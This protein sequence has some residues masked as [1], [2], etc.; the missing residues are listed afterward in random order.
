MIEGGERKLIVTG[1]FNLLS[2]NS[3]QSGIE[4]C[5]D[6]YIVP[7][8]LYKVETNKRLHEDECRRLVSVSRASDWI[9]GRFTCLYSSGVPLGKLESSIRVDF[10]KL[11]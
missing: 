11:L 1:S 10:K 5:S 6:I 3:P 8:K 9:D 2:P 7:T 4:M